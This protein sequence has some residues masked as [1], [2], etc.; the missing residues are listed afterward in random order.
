MTNCLV[1]PSSYVEVRDDEMEY[2][3]GEWSWKGFWGWVCGGAVAGSIGLGCVGAAGGSCIPGAGTVAGA[4]TGAGI[5]F[6]A[7]AA[8]GALGY[9]L[10]GGW[11]D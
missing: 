7:G 1:M 8:I 5:G 3:N 4:F 9:L 10:F 2:S 11:S 6:V